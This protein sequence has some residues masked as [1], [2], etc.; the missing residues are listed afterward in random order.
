MLGEAVVDELEPEDFAADDDELPSW[1]A[2][3]ELVSVPLLVAELDEFVPAPPF[4]A[5]ALPE[6]SSAVELGDDEVDVFAAVG[7]DEFVPVPAFAPPALPE[8]S[9]VA[10]LVADEVDDV[11]DEV[12]VAPC[13]LAVEVSPL[14]QASAA[15]APIAMERA[16]RLENFMRPPGLVTIERS[17]VSSI[18]MPVRGRRKRPVWCRTSRRMRRTANV[19]GKHPMTVQSGGRAAAG[20]DRSPHLTGSRSECRRSRGRQTT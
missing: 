11:D 4:E 19:H 14:P 3:E 5:P 16:D 9:P 6:L 20:V 1:L 13:E 15:P 8:P 12:S 10:E 7:L 18:A 2:L 17:R